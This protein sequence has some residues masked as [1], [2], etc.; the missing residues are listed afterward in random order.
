MLSQQILKTL[1]YFDIQDHPLTLLEIKKYMLDEG[2]G[3]ALDKS[4]A[5]G[6]SAILNCLDN[7]LAGNVQNKY[8]FYFL[9][10][11]ES[12]AESRWKNN[13]Y[14]VPRLKKAKRILPLVRFVP[15]IAAIALTGSEARGN[16]KE[17]SDIDLLVLTETNRIWLGRL[18]LTA[19]FQILGMRR[20]GNKI[21]DRFCLNHY[22]RA[23]K[24]LDADKNIYTA[25]E[26]V[27]LI[28]FYG[29]KSV[30]DFQ[31]KNIDWIKNYL[32]EPI[33][34]KFDAPKKSGFARFMEIMFANFAGDALERAAGRYQ[35]SRIRVQQNI[36]IENDELS[37]HPGS[38]GKQV[39][40]RMPFEV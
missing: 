4:D 37:F 24:V 15:F 3:K 23:G 18:F 6:L 28:P 32:A 29:G 26:Y 25:V 27:S 14:S 40:S 21:A 2:G 10:G 31:M 38:K 19:F 11:R 5:A 17:G 16:S 20:H 36:V 39:L 30:Y 8:G 1:Q 22:V 34:I 9:S 35:K 12:I 7:E 33:I 13:F